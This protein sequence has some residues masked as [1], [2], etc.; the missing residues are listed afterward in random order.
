MFE[1][2][3]SRTESDIDTDFV[4]IGYLPLANRI[5]HSAFVIQ[6]EGI[7]Y[8]FHYEGSAIDFSEIWNNYFHKITASVH[9]E[10]VPAFMA[11]CEQIKKKANP[12]YGYFY[13]GENYDRSGNHFGMRDLG[14]RMTCVG[15]CLNVL[16]GFF[17]E[18]YI[19]YADWKEDTHKQTG[20][21]EKYCIRHNIDIS[22]VKASHRRI[23]PLEFLTSGFFI[24]FPIRK[25]QI[26]GKI[27]EVAE[28][29]QRKIKSRLN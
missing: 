8:E 5:T 29:I 9:P 7:L 1:R 10:E 21:L 25:I 18:D 28:I 11:M 17:D 22:K 27:D 12:K 4:A 20:Y 14:E 2:V 13:S 19:E 24:D 6:Y 23:T 15:F 16:K 3:Y 26:D